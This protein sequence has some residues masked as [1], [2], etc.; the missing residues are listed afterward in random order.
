[1]INSHFSIVGKE[2][3]ENNSKRLDKHLKQNKWKSLEWGT[4]KQWIENGRF[5]YPGTPGVELYHIN[6]KPFYVYN[7]CETR[8]IS[9][10]DKYFEDNQ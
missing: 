8:E 10:L 4:E 2:Y 9:L 6:Q 1:M 3:S 5:V 7:F